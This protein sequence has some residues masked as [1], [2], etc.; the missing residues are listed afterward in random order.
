MVDGHIAAT[1]K[2]TIELRAT[3]WLSIISPHHASIENVLIRSPTENT[4]EP[5]IILSA[6]SLV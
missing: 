6:H 2:K 4:N 3:E 1:C 5:I